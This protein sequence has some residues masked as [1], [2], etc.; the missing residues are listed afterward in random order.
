M[1]IYLDIDGT[2]LNRDGSSADGLHDFI[3]YLTKHHTCFWLTTHCRH[4]GDIEHVHDYLRPRLSAATF[5]LIKSVLP[6]RWNILKTEAID[7]NED[8]LWFDDSVMVSER[9]ELKLHDSINGLQIVDLEKEGLQPLLKRV[10]P[11]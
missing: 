4:D 6:T 3:S 10:R 8:F 5:Q 7:F 2:L 11:L 1:N 9:N